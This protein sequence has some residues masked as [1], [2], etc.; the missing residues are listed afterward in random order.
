MKRLI[1]SGL[2]PY[3][4]NKESVSPVN[5][6]L[7]QYQAGILDKA[8][9]TNLYKALCA[10]ANPATPVGYSKPF[11]RHGTHSVAEILKSG[12]LRGTFAAGNHG[13]QYL[14]SKVFMTTPTLLEKKDKQIRDSRL[15]SRLYGN[16]GINGLS[17]PN[18]L[19][20]YSV[21]AQAFAVLGKENIRPAS[22]VKIKGQQREIDQ[23]GIDLSDGDDLAKTMETQSITY[24]TELIEKRLIVS[25]VKKDI[26][27]LTPA[28]FQ[29]AFARIA[30]PEKLTFTVNH[31]KD[32][33]LDVTPQHLE[34]AISRIQASSTAHQ[35]SLAALNRGAQ[36]PAVLGFSPVRDMANHPINTG[37]RNMI[38][39]YRNENLPLG[40]DIK[41]GKAVELEIRSPEHLSTLLLHGRLEDYSVSPD[42]VIR[43]KQNVRDDIN[44]KSHENKT[45]LKKAA[46][47][48]ETATYLSGEQ[49]AYFKS[50]INEK[51]DKFFDKSGTASIKDL[52]YF[53]RQELSDH[54]QNES[55]AIFTESLKRE[56]A[57]HSN[58][59]PLPNI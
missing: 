58:L 41:G 45:I 34:A 40:G 38:H 49:L 37:T 53:Q 23:G 54:L 59:D 28:D 19:K 21:Y 13:G 31:V 51:I 15:I 22:L 18:C 11:A 48:D 20:A 27:T 26:R 44:P 42:M 24:L 1:G 50:G 3:E 10:S 17:A 29:Q 2:K 8:S 5:F 57:D 32:E 36:V 9:A 30:V 47:K 14:E 35:S 33:T 6:L 12:E 7:D 56:K 46:Q 39:Q 52:D 4:V 43:L 25:F 16:P 55:R